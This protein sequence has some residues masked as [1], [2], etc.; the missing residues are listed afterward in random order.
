M[1]EMLDAGHGECLL[2]RV[3]IRKIVTAA[4]HHFDDDRYRLGGLVIM[5]N[6]VHLLVQCLGDTRLKRMC[7]SWKH[8]TAREINKVIAEKK[9]ARESHREM[10]SGKDSRVTF[11]QAE[12]YDHIVRS[13]EQFEYYRR[14]IA[15]NPIKAGLR[16][17]EYALFL[18]EVERSP[19]SPS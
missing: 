11:W 1:H 16:A 2:R 9:V 8:F 15:E 5:P 6:H 18:P 19:A 13:W 12:T 4:L 10:N 14:Y 3:D 7:Y 17:D